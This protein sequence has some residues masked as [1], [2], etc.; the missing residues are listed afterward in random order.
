MSRVKD[1]AQ[2]LDRVGKFELKDTEIMHII[3]LADR[4]KAACMNGV[5]E[6]R[7][8]DYYNLREALSKMGDQKLEEL[9][10]LMFFGRQIS[11]FNFDHHAAASF[12]SNVDEKRYSCIRGD[13]GTEYIAGKLPLGDWLRLAWKVIR[14]GD[15]P[16]EFFR[17]EFFSYDDGK[18]H[19]VEYDNEVAAWRAF[20]ELINPKTSEEYNCIRLIGYSLTGR[21]ET[22]MASVMLE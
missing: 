17:I 6:E 19:D 20:R 7:E 21:A 4:R 5:P 14:E 10:C 22:H 11:H 12:V 9:A 15:R 2:I 3:E 16:D 1:M 13:D 8:E 18:K